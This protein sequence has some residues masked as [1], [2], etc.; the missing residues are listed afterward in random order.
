MYQL[1]VDI[2]DGRT[3]FLPGEL[4]AGTVR[5]Q[6]SHHA[7]REVELQVLWQATGAGPEELGIVKSLSFA[8]PRPVD[9]RTFHLR[10]PWS[11]YSLAGSLV[12]IDWAVRLLVNRGAAS[13][14]LTIVISPMREVL[15]LADDAGAP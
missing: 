5:W 11:P 4:L 9:Q 1:H 13:H 15:L 12:R 8:N 2:S 7:V 10:L 6:A 14:L 3:R